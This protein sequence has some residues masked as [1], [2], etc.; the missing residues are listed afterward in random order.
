MSRVKQVTLAGV[1]A[2]PNGLFIEA[3]FTGLA[4][5]LAAASSLD[6]PRQVQLDSGATDNS[7]DTA[8]IIGT[9]RY[10]NTITETLVAPAANLVTLSTKTYASVASISLGSAVVDLQGGWSNVTLSQ[11]VP[12]DTYVDKMALAV[13]FVFPSGGTMNVDI[14]RTY[15]NMQRDPATGMPRTEEVVADDLHDDPTLAGMT[16]T[17]RATITDPVTAIRLNMNSWTAGTA[18]MRLVQARGRP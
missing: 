18:M 12:V 13:E 2:D 5:L 9:D 10:G 14:E 3:S 17:S 7:G 1:A 4:T 15:E 6:P 8:T 16:A 11:W